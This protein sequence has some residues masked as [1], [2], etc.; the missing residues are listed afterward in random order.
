LAKSLVKSPVEADVWDGI[1]ATPIAYSPPACSKPHQGMPVTLELGGPWAFYRN[2][3]AAHCLTAVMSFLKPQTALSAGHNLWVPLLLHNDAQE[4]K[5]VTLHSYLPDGWSPPAKDV[6]YHLEP[7]S[8]YPAQMFL[9]APATKPNAPPQELRWSIA[10]GG[11]DA[12]E[13]ALTVYME[14]NGVPQ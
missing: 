11:K 13:V 10:D 4:P 9:I 12:G 2:F 3:Y 1:D 7:R 14:F 8:T 6:L 5:D